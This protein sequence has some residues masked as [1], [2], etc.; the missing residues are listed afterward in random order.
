MDVERMIG[1]AVT[2]AQLA[3]GTSPERLLRSSGSREVSV[4][5][6]K[7]GESRALPSA[8]RW[9]SEE[10]EYVQQVW[11]YMSLEEIGE[12]L[13]RS[14]VAIT[15]LRKRKGWP[16]PSK[17][18]H[19]LTARKVAVIMRKCGKTIT[20]LIRL[21][22]LPGRMLPA[23]GSRNIHVVR[24]LT[25]ERWLVNPANWIYFDHRKITDRRLRRLVSLAKARW[26]DEWLTTGQAAKLLGVT[27]S[28]SVQARIKR[29]QLPARRW[30]NWHVLRSDV[31]RQ[32]VVPG[33]GS[34]GRTRTEYTERGD[35]ILQFFVAE[36]KGWREIERLMGPRYSEKRAPFHYKQLQRRREATL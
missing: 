2:D 34:P 36:G 18:P 15:V 24:R 7:N 17:Q 33:R 35:S 9:T 4:L 21:G 16:A 6:R 5:R 11:G 12:A 27:N 1:L 29:G 31:E 10:I 3:T 32:H 26:P 8:N 25:F 23:G 28:N 19:E 13:G 30:A 14:A 20:H 22:I